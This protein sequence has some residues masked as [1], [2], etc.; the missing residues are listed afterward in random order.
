MIYSSVE[1]E[2]IK[3]IKKIQNKKYRDIKNLFIVEGEHLVK[4]AYKTNNL[5]TLIKEEDFDISL[6]IETLTVTKKVMKYLSELDNPSKVIGVCKKNIGNI[7][8]NKILALDGVQDP[9]NLGTIIRSSVAFDVDTILIGKNCVD[10][11]NSKV[12]RATQGLIFNCN[13]VLCDL[14]DTLTNMKEYK[15]LATKVDGGTSLDKIK[16]TN[17]FVVVMGSEGMG[18]S[19]EILSL[20][21]EYLYIDMNSN[22]ES[23]NVAVATSIILYELRGN[24]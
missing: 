8:G 18:V 10:I 7:K 15:I 23:L 17:K 16:T 6:D 20:C 14:I 4:E 21:N 1:N 3:E 5:V 24:K 11:Y 13:F 2:K 22:C 12:I 9:G 19:K